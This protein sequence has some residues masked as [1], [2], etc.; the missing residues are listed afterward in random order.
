MKWQ[1]KHQAV[2]VSYTSHIDSDHCCSGLQETTL[3]CMGSGCFLCRMTRG[4]WGGIC[5]WENET[6]SSFLC[7]KPRA[8]EGLVRGYQLKTAGN[9]IF[10]SSHHNCIPNAY[11]QTCHI[12]K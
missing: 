11:G 8:E 4:N 6:E 9:E 3:N 7:G 1:N 5:I 12:L 2:H 10:L